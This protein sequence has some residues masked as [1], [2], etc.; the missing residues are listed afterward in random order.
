LPELAHC[1][2]FI[3]KEGIFLDYFADVLSIYGNRYERRRRA[4]INVTAPK[5]RKIETISEENRG[6]EKV[7]R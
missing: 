6:Y 1:S 5:F 2:A 4:R 7:D 3:F